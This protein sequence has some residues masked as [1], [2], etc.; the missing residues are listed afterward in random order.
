MLS[1]RD[2]YVASTFLG[3]F[4]SERLPKQVRKYPASLIANTDPAS[5][6]E[7]HWIVMYFPEKTKN[8]FLDSYGLPPAFTRILL[9][10]T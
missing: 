7:Q 9:Q 2:P 3:V 1:T 6:P 4:P 8:E 5:K 10:S